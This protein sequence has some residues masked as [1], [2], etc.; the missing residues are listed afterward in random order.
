MTSVNQTS[1][2]ARYL[3]ILSIVLLLL[4]SGRILFVPMSYGLLIAIV[5]YPSC[6]WLEKHHW[7]K[8]MAVAASIA[9]V[10]ILFVGLAWVLLLQLKTFQQDLPLLKEKISP[11]INELQLWIEKNFAISPGEQNEW[12]QNQK[13]GAA[14]SGILLP[15]LLK[16]VSGNL[17]ILFVIPIFAA[18]F[19]YNRRSFVNF[20][21]LLYGEKNRNILNSVLKEIVHSYFSYIKGIVLVYII[22]GAL[23][24]IGLIALGVRHAILF[25]FLTAIMTMIPY[26]GII[27][28]ALVPISLAWIDTGSVWVPLGIVAV[29]SFVQY[30][31]ANVIFP[32][33]VGAKLNVSTWAMMVFIIAGG[34]VWG[35]SGMILFIPFAGIL[36]IATGHVKEW[37]AWNV[38]LSR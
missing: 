35:V 12:F 9:V 3:V 10:I 37:K 4:Y 15:A 23:N 32:R 7:P 21:Q 29:F 27:I 34:I 30:L 13:K 38:L 17:F 18:L 26:I 36:K 8:A 11:S 1:S 2:V 31:E 25:G 19:L 6:S 22:V 20:V 16:S 5:L 24:S 33:V 14:S 28:S